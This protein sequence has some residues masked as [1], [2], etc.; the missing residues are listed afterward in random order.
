MERMTRHSPI[1]PFDE[2]AARACRNRWAE[3]AKPLGS[4]GLLEGIVEQISGLT[5]D[6]DYHLDRRAVLV[7]CADNGVVAQGVTQTGSEVTAAVAGGIARGGLTINHMAAVAHADVV[8]VDMGMNFPLPVSGLLDC[9]VG[10]GT[11]DMTIGPAMSREQA[12]EAVQIG[13]D[14]VAEMKERGYQILCTGEVGIGNTTTS[15][16]LAAV[17]LGRAVEEV[18]G[19]GAGLSTDGLGRKISAIQRAI[20]VNKPKADD[21]IDALAKVGGFDLAAMCGIFLGGALCRVP[22]MVDGLISSVAALCAVGLRSECKS[23]MLASH[24]S[25]EPAGAMLLEA[26]G[27]HP[28]ICAGLRVGEGTGTVAALPMLDMAYG[29]YRK[30][31]TFDQLAIETYRP[32]S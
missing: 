19:R 31:P 3:I 29:V 15:S 14:L 9:R 2:E 20:E 11:A 26:L 22:I 17:L 8:A 12:E 6:H 18:T 28:L 30:M 10:A 7:M 27:L 16:A 5:G 32:L 1:P 25:A 13:I 4:L 21:P 23:A 24:I